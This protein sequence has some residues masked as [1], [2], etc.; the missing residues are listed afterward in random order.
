[1]PYRFKMHYMSHYFATFIFIIDLLNAVKRVMSIPPLIILVY[2]VPALFLSGRI[3]T[4]SDV[5][6]L[7]ASLFKDIELAPLHIDAERDLERR[8][9]SS[10]HYARFIPTAFAPEIPHFCAF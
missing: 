8:A 7:T 5:N 9:L 10:G 3:T 4:R 1:M 2:C 6:A